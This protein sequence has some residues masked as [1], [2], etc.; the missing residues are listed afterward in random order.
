MKG[1]A[2]LLLEQRH[3]RQAMIVTFKAIHFKQWP[4]YLKLDLATQ[5]KG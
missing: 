4:V 5:R 2:Y 1:K 3:D